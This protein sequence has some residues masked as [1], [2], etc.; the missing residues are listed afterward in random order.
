MTVP[1]TREISAEQERAIVALINTNDI[2]VAAC[3]AGVE[4]EILLVWLGRDAAFIAAFGHIA[5]ARNDEA[6]CALMAEL[7]WEWHS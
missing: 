5:Q 6:F 2:D 4:V 3:R 7:D 1:E